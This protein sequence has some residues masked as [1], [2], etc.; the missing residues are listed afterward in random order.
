MDTK[1]QT[2]LRVQRYRKKQKALH[3]GNA[4]DVTPEASDVTPGVTP[5]HADVTLYCEECGAEMEWSCRACIV[6]GASSRKEH[7]RALTEFKKG[8]AGDLEFSKDKQA[9]RK[10]M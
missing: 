5:G 8:R 10:R 7:D 6:K 3:H 1:E 2:R 9:S 4:E